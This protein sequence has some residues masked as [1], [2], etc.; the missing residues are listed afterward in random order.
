MLT[1]ERALILSACLTFTG[2][3]ILSVQAAAERDGL[4]RSQHNLAS[5][6]AAAD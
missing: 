1:L 6:Q 5:R 3:I 4:D 2:F